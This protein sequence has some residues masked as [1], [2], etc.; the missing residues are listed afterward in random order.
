MIASAEMRVIGG[1]FVVFHCIQFLSALEHDKDFFVK[2][3]LGAEEENSHGIVW[4]KTFFEIL[5]FDKGI[6]GEEKENTRGMV[7]N[8]TSKFQNIALAS[9]SSN[10][11]WLASC[12]LLSCFA[13]SYQHS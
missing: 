10:P 13:F 3:K 11:P 9:A 8:E 2:G 6:L 7:W 5:F 12:F 4:S 1:F